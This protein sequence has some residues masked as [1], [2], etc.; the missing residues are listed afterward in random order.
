LHTELK[1][2]IKYEKFIDEYFLR[3]IPSL[4]KYIKNADEFNDI[5]LDSNGRS[6]AQMP[7]AKLESLDEK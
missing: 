5:S 4:Q 2:R 7:L 6:K 3:R 1:D